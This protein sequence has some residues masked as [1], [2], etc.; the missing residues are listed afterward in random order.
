[1][2]VKIVDDSFIFGLLAGELDNRGGLPDA[3]VYETAVNAVRGIR[4]GQSRWPVDTSFSQ[5]NFFVELDGSIWNQADYAKYVERDTNAIHDY[6][7]ENIGSLLPSSAAL[8]L[9]T[10]PEPLS[11]RQ[12]I[13]FRQAQPRGSARQRVDAAGAGGAAFTAD[14]IRSGAGELPAGAGSAAR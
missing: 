13:Q 6:L 8:V 9:N 2:A 5:Q 12:V 3:L 1:M 7:R 11:P 14:D 4:G 10:P